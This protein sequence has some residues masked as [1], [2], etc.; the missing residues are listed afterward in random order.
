MDAILN[1]DEPHYYAVFGSGIKEVGPRIPFYSAPASNLT[2]WTF[3]GA[4]WEPSNNES[5]G[6]ALETGSYA[7][8]FE[9]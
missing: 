9:V 3:L 1:Q 2:D 7:Y 5:L 6:S 4:L 8:N